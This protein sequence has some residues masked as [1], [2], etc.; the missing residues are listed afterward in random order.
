MHIFLICKVRGATEEQ[1]AEQ[2][3][4]VESLERKGH[5]V[6]WPHRDTEQNDPKR[7]TG[8]CWTTFGG[9]FGAEEV[10][11]LFDPTSEGFVA[12]M[13]MTFALNELWKRESLGRAKG[14]GWRRVVIVN[15]EAV[16]EKIKKEVEE[17]TA[18]GVDPRFTKS[19]TMVLKNLA[20]ET[21]SN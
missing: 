10:H 19:Y 2:R 15:P 17:Q 20:D 16:E 12:D 4:Y 5:T 7:G 9:I 3:T 18:K 13:M 6:H 21:K 14:I 11:V 8:I 1:I